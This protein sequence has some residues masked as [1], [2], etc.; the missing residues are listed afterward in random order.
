MYKLETR[1]KPRGR[2]VREADPN[3]QCV[4]V[5]K[6]SPNDLMLQLWAGKRYMLVA[7]SPQ[8]ARDIASELVA[9]ADKIQLGESISGAAL[10]A[11]ITGS[12]HRQEPLT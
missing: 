10:T 12:D 9:V 7:L 5:Y 3:V 4:R 6:N 11:I 1:N 8:E 2:L